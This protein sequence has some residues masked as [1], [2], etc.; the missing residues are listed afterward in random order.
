MAVSFLGSRF[1]P[2]PLLSFWGSYMVTRR[3]FLKVAGV[4]AISPIVSG[5]W[6]C[7]ANAMP[8]AL[9]VAAGAFTS[10]NILYTGL[11]IS[12]LKLVGNFVEE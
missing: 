1:L 9:A 4:T 5:L 12:G 7:E 8:A 11:A 10:E 2:T 3:D 6:P